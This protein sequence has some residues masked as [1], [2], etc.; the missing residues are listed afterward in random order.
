MRNGKFQLKNPLH[1]GA[2]RVADQFDELVTDDDIRKSL[3][4][5]AQGEMADDL[6]GQGIKPFVNFKTIRQKYKKEGF[7]I[8]LDQVDYG[9][10][11][12][13]IC[14]IEL[15]IESQDKMEEAV[16]RILEFA[17]GYGLNPSYVRGKVHEYLKR[18]RPEHL[19]ILID[20]GAVR[21]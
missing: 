6:A 14:E 5:G 8:D 7:I 15:M 10:T 4:I 1:H 21:S 13:E 17:K 20:A 11:Q 19:Q 18:Y 9:D 12:F 3:G 16:E 2:D